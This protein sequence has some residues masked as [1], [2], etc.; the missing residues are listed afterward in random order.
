MDGEECW[1]LIDSDA[2]MSTISEAHA[3]KL[4][5]KHHVLDRISDIEGR[6]GG[7]VPYHGYVEVQLDIPWIAAFREDVIMLIL[8]DSRYTAKVPIA[9][10]AL[11]I[12]GALDLVMDTEI[13]Q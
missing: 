2:M 8:D 10:E 9:I 12:H 13:K 11:H 5:L 1:A 6:G 3:R 4:G 7:W